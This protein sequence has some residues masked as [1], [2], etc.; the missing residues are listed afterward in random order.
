MPEFKS[1]TAMFASFPKAPLSLLDSNIW[2][3]ITGSEGLAETA[4]ETFRQSF[5]MKRFNTK[6]STPWRPSKAER[7]GEHPTLLWTHTLQNSISVT[8]GYRYG[9]GKY[10]I[11]V[12]TDE[13]KFGS[14]GSHPGFCYAAIHNAPDGSY[15]YG[16]WGGP[17][18][19][20]QFMGHSSVIDEYIKQHS[21]DIFKGFPISQIASV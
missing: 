3:F 2:N 15:T 9:A 19:Q 16:T 5:D 1:M 6:G 10:S 4:A 8:S 17:S 11:A 7:S 13:S 14:A 12:I 18:I 21:I 20:R